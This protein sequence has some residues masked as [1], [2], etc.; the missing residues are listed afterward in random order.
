MS[1]EVELP[2]FHELFE[3][4][5]DDHASRMIVGSEVREV[6]WK[7]RDALRENATLAKL[8]EE[9]KE[10]YSSVVILHRELKLELTDAEI[11]AQVWAKQHDARVAEIAALRELM[12]S[13]E[14]EDFFK[15]IELEATH[16]RKRWGSD[17]DAGKSPADWFWL[18]GYLA[19]KCLH[20]HDHGNTEKAL[21]HTISTAGALANWH[22]AIKGV[23]NMR[24]GI[25]EPVEAEQAVDAH[26]ATKEGY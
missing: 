6:I 26:E 10:L 8:V 12:D 13:P 21:H 2:A 3:R 9:W 11:R 4:S 18:I 15:G 19:G 5:K 24:P 1:E 22:R 23:G 16:Q 25:A 14:T 7:L 17:H 20:A